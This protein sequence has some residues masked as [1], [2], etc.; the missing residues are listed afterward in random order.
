MLL[1]DPLTASLRGNKWKPLYPNQPRY[2]VDPNYNHLL[3]Q[4]ESDWLAFSDSIM[5]LTDSKVE[6]NSLI[7]ARKQLYQAYI[8]RTE[9]LFTRHSDKIATAVALYDFLIR[10]RLIDIGK[11]KELYDKLD[12]VVKLQF[13]WNKDWPS[14]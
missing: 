10:N 2:I 9:Q 11:T 14:H 4:F 6:D 13:D 5:S 3:R 1:F 7:E 8:A 12:D